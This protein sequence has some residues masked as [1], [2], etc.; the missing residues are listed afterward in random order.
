MMNIPWSIRVHSLWSITDSRSPPLTIT[1]SSLK[2]ETALL[3]PNLISAQLEFLK[4]SILFQNHVFCVA[5]GQISKYDRLAQDQQYDKRR[6]CF[7]LN[8]L[9]KIHY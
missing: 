6:Y 4:N 9:K 5:Q 1:L 8:E 3:S 2:N 7:S